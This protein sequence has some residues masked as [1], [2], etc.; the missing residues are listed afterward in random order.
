M[1]RPTADKAKAGGFF[2]LFFSD[3]N[4]PVTKPSQSPRGSGS[5]GIEMKEGGL[6][7]E[8]H[9]PSTKNLKPG[10]LDMRKK[11]GRVERPTKRTTISINHNEKGEQLGTL[12]GQCDEEG[13]KWRG[14]CRRECAQQSSP[15]FS[16]LPHSPRTLHHLAEK[17][18]DFEKFKRY[19]SL[20]CTLW[21]R[22]L[23]FASGSVSVLMTSYIANF[24][25]LLL[26]CFVRSQV[27]G[28][29]LIP[30]DLWKVADPG[31]M[32]MQVRLLL[33]PCLMEKFILHI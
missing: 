18:S 5:V 21:T 22:R 30:Y 13:L 15:K 25:M 24:I 23:K 29:F 26:C 1:K 6:G 12:R 17:A 2:P 31:Q 8:H 3:D 27:S 28:D 7:D 20:L 33:L 9:E 11:K 19:F 32:G 14:V 10:L 16:N 4:K